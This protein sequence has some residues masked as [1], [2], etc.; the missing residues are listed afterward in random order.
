MSYYLNDVL[1]HAIDYLTSPNKTDYDDMKLMHRY[2]LTNLRVRTK[3][4]K[5]PNSDVY[6][7][8]TMY[9]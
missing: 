9:G 8:G 4:D 6:A 1:F 2:I 7:G 5:S 3:I